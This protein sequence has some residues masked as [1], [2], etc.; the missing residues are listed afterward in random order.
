MIIGIGTKNPAKL[1]A[2]GNAI[3]KLKKTFPAA[4][5]NGVRFE[6]CLA[7]SGVSDMPLSTEETTLGARN[8]ALFTYTFLE[9]SHLPAFTIGMEGG[10]FPVPQS[11][12][13]ADYMLQNWVYVYNGQEGFYGVS[14]GVTLP[15]KM[16]RLLITQKKELAEVIDTET[17]QQNIRSK[18]GAFG[19]L[20]EDLYTRSQ[21]F[22]S[23]LIN[24]FTPFFNSKYY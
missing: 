11:N 24:A 10:V 23:A 5:K 6:S 22:E 13:N 8:R 19:I 16:A 15:E 17:G 2:C 3:E 1:K 14:A 12:G 7:K 18:N 21:A 9:K 4:F 20:T